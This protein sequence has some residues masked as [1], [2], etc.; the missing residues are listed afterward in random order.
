[1]TNEETKLKRQNYLISVIRKYITTEQVLSL[2]D[3]AECLA[4]EI[5]D[6]SG[7]LKKYKRELKK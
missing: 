5:E 3:I 6:L 1:M 7:F 4:E 2:K